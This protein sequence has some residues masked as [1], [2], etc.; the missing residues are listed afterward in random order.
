MKR[1]PLAVL[2]I[3]I[4]FAT[5]A[6][7]AHADDAEANARRGHVQ[8][9]EA[10]MATT[11][12]DPLRKF[13]DEHFAPEYRASFTDARPLLGH[14]REIRAALNNFGGLLVNRDEDG[15]MHMKFLLP[16]GSRA[17]TFRTQ[18]A[19]PYLITAFDLDAGLAPPEPGMEIKPITWETLAARMDE[20]AKNGFSGAVYVVRDGKV[21]LAKGY[22]EADRD[23]LYHNG[24]HTIFAIGSTPIDFTRAAVLKLE[25]KGKLKTSDRIS[26][27]FPDAPADKKDI[28]IDELMSGQSGLANFHHR[29]G[30]DANPDLTWIDR[31]TAVK[32]IFERPLLFKPGEG[33]AHS[34]SAWVLLAALVET[35]SGQSYGDFLQQEL[36]KP[37]GMTSTFLHE[38]LRKVSDR[39]IAIGYEAESPGKDNSPKYWGRTSWLVMGSGGMASTV[40]DLAKFITAVHGG[41]LLA[42]KQAKKYGG[43]GGL[44]AGG[45]DRG[46]LCMHAERGKD[47]MVLMS[48]AHKG[49]GDLPS[50]VGQAL[51]KMVLGRD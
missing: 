10:L 9:I 32:R 50:S 2:C 30:I 43:E 46:F 15:T 41:T 40:E 31:A 51:G 44:W 27:Y 34:H 14:L 33:N 29:P 5:A 26:Q 48:N 28:T 42:A 21:V 22:G 39:R 23:L 38:G 25:E 47:L 17:L 45:D 13:A 11:G 37:A 18:A 49:P 1:A 20:E 7:R 6:V 16:A 35:V 8:A 3:A 19:V 4:A 36:F 12:D 24:T